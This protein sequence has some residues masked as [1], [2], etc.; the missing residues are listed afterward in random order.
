[1]RILRIWTSRGVCLLLIGSMLL[2]N[3]VLRRS[4]RFVVGRRCVRRL[5]MGVCLMRGRGWCLVILLGWE[6]F[7]VRLRDWL[8]LL[9]IFVRSNLRLVILLLVWVLILFG[10]CRLLLLLGRLL[11]RV[12]RRSTDLLPSVSMVLW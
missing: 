7:L 4:L 11:R 6:R 2:L 8:V 5:K 12:D 10:F 9:L 1:M 3:V